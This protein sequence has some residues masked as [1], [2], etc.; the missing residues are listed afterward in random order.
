[1]QIT[2][3]LK[4]RSN[5]LRNNNNNHNLTRLRLRWIW[6]MRKYCNRNRLSQIP[7]MTLAACS[8][9]ICRCQE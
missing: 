7:L 8:K 4:V 1:M 9:I 5:T 2:Y 3:F 6:W